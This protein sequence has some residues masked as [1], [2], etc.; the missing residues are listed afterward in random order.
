MKLYK[1]TY[2]DKNGKKKKTACWYLTFV[3]NRRVRRR[4]SLFTVKAESEKAAEKIQHLLDSGG[5]VSPALVKWIETL[6]VRITE[7]LKAFGLMDTVRLS[8]HIGKTLSEHIEDFHRALLARGNTPT[9]AKQIKNVV[10]TTLTGC[11]F[12][13]WSDVDA[14]RLYTYL[15]DLRG[16]DGI[17]QRTFNYNLSAIKQFA[18][19]LCQERRTT[20]NPI[21]Y[22]KRMTQ[23]E[24][25]TKR[26]ALTIDEQIKLLEKTEAGQTHHNMTGH[27]RRLCYTLALQTGLRANEL[28]SL[29]T[30]CFDFTG[31]TVALTG[32]YTKNKKLAVIDLKPETAAEMKQHLA[33]KLPDVAAFNMP[34]QPAKMIQKDLEAAGIPYETDEGKADFHSLRHS[35]ITNLA[36]AGVHPSDAQALARHSSVTLTMD[37]YTHTTRESLRRIINRQ[38]DL[39]AKQNEQKPMTSA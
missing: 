14:N 7:K 17:G 38:P 21:Q 26:R 29:T 6:P 8:E 32:A 39:T 12:K 3:D 11:G 9:Y 25:R 13:N 33:G 1:P 18:K 24:K 28:R 5:D 10:E 4:L 30:A 35:F 31:N 34:D 27:E 22:L 20:V 19:W 15:A 36:R 2:T 16:D 37:H 23:T